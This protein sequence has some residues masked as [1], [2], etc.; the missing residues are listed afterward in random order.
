MIGKIVYCSSFKYSSPIKGIVLDKESEWSSVYIVQPT[1]IIE[2]GEEIE[3][4]DN[5]IDLLCFDVR[6]LKDSLEDIVPAPKSK[7]YNR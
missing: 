3:L 1:H 5:E 6:G 7:I 2:N 4:K